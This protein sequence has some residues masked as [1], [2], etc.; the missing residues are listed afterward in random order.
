MCRKSNFIFL[1]VN[2]VIHCL[3]QQSSTALYFI[4]LIFLFLHSVNINLSQTFYQQQSVSQE[5]A[6]YDL[7][8]LSLRHNSNWLDCSLNLGLL[9]QNHNSN[10]S[11]V[12]TSLS[13]C[14]PD[15]PHERYAGTASTS[16]EMFSID[17]DIRA[18]IN[19]QEDDLKRFMQ[20]KVLQMQYAYTVG[21]C[22]VVTG[23]VLI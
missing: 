12:S 18:D 14:L 20:Q 17:N 19:R 16:Q 15:Y 2:K 8:S 4:I 5:A 10:Q 22:M 21:E 7:C 11:G 6:S 23:P 1:Q 3:I 9:N 13:L